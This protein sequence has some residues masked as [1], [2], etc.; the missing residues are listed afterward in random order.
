M[1]TIEDKM[2]S[3]RENAEDR[4]SVL[5][6]TALWASLTGFAPN[7]L[8]YGRLER[9]FTSAVVTSGGVVFWEALFFVAFAVG[10]AEWMVGWKHTSA[11]F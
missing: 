7:D 4:F 10:S 11:I 6:I 8:W 3:Y 1:Q 9:L 2:L 5:K